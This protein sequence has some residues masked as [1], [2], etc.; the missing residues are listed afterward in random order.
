MC[1]YKGWQLFHSDLLKQEPLWDRVVTSTR[2]FL[3][4]PIAATTF[5]AFFPARLAA[6]VPEYSQHRHRIMCN[7]CSVYIF[8]HFSSA[9][10]PGHFSRLRLSGWN[11][12]HFLSTTAPTRTKLCCPDSEGHWFGFLDFWLSSRSNFR[13]FYWTGTYQVWRSVGLGF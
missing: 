7:L 13:T 11:K 1:Q 4:S 5:W 10:N 8:W 12:M 2:T 6:H 9:N 3:S